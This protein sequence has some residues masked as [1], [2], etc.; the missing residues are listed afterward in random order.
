MGMKMILHE[1]GVSGI[2]EDFPRGC[3]TGSRHPTLGLKEERFE[4]V[5]KQTAEENI[6]I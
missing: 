6:W 2:M 3:A 5:R 1:Q 4:G